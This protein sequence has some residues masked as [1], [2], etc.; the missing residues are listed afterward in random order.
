MVNSGSLFALVAVALLAVSVSASNEKLATCCTKVTNKEIKEPIMG[1]LVQRARHPCVN[2]VIFQT[3][4]GLFCSY[5]RAP[6]VLRKIVE[7]ERAKARSTIPSAVSTSPTSLLSIITSTTS[8]PSPSTALPS[9]SSTSNTSPAETFSE[10][11]DERA[12]LWLNPAS[13]LSSPSYLPSLILRLPLELFPLSSELQLSPQHLSVHQALQRRRFTAYLTSYLSSFLKMVNSGSLFALVAV[14]L[15]AVTVSGSEIKP[16]SCCTKV[17]NKEI[18][19]PILGYLVQRARHPCVNAVIFQTQS[20]LFCSYVR[21]PW[22]L[23]KIAEFE[24]AKARSTIPSAVS[25]S[26][27]SLLSIITST[28]SPPSPSTALPSSSSTSN[29]SPAGT[30][31]ERRDE[32]ASV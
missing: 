12:S 16:A 13:P 25:T 4:S 8:P 27:T 18:K 9:S 20:G 22:V 28:T 26:P 3:Q 30:L 32:R 17:T 10:S 23:P 29:T 7:F 6:W 15:V 21:A 5:V 31:S 2:A 1:Y 14:V 24:K 19:E 11:R